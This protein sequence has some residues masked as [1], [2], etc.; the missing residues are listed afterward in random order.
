MA[1]TGDDKADKDTKWNWYCK[2]TAQFSS[3]RYLIQTLGEQWA[4]AG[5]TVDDNDYNDND[6]DDDDDDDNGDDDSSPIYL[7]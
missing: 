5:S 2:R 4:D 6:D 7:K 1:R 3:K